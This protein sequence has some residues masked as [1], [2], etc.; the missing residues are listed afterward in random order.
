MTPDFWHERWRNQQI[1][2][3][4]SQ[5]NPLLVKHWPSLGADDSAQVLVPLCGKSLDLTYFMAAHSKV[6]G[7]ELNQSAVEQFF[8]ETDL[9]YDV[10][11]VAQLACY[12]TE[13]LSLYQGDFFELSLNEVGRCDFFYD[14]AA[15]IAWPESMR[16]R[17]LEQL[18]HLL[19]AGAKGLLIT[20]DYPQHQIDGPPF[21]VTENW[22]EDNLAKHFSFELLESNDILSDSP[23]FVK[24]GVQRLVENSYYLTKK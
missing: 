20:L 23:K 9:P 6:V 17:Y 19:P 3:H 1:G 16:S 18:A 14:R 22:L 4:L 11:Q 7:C 8:A 10:I 12:Q 5:V 24:K 13:R 21:A 15:M 2:F